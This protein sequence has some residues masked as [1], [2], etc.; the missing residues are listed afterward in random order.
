[1]LPAALRAYDA[2]N[3]RVP[4]GRLNAWLAAVARHHPPPVVSRVVGTRGRGQGRTAATARVGLRLKYAAQVAARPPTFA[5]WANRPDVPEAYRRFL[6]N[7]LREEFAL[8]GT[9]VRL[10]EDAV[11]RALLR[12]VTSTFCGEALA[13]TLLQSSNTPRRA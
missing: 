5:V 7:A 3:A 9:P 13:P 11:A 1:L 4:T 6:L 2:W 8:G 12:A 10:T